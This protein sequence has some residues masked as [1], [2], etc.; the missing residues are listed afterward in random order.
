MGAGPEAQV[1]P[2]R[3]EWKGVEGSARGKQLLVGGPH[4]QGGQAKSAV[5]QTGPGRSSRWEIPVREGQGC[6]TG[7]P[8]RGGYELVLHKNEPGTA[9][10]VVYVP[11]LPV[12]ATF[13]LPWRVRKTPEKLSCPRGGTALRCQLSALDKSLRRIPSFDLCSPTRP[14]G[15]LSLIMSV[16]ALTGGNSCLLP[17]A[18]LIGPRGDSEWRSE[19]PRA[20]AGM[21]LQGLQDLRPPLAP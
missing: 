18:W 16:F 6:G 13:P 3:R 1:L 2:G 10:N 19:P 12:R 15:L 21:P 17:Y 5:C 7:S 9:P 4:Q 11:S 20:P 8:G 14:A